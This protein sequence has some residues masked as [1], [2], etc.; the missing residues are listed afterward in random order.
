VHCIFTKQVWKLLI[1]YFTLPVAW[2]GPTFSACLTD[3]VT[4]KSA[5]PTLAVY[6]CWQVW[7]ER[8]NATFED[9]TPSI[10]A[11][12]HR[13]RASF[14]WQPSLIKAFTPKVCEISLSLGYTLVCFDGAVESTGLCCG[15]GG[16]FRTH[17]KRITKWF[18]NCG[19]GTN[20]K[21]ELL[22]LWT[23]LA[24]ASLWSI[25]HLQILGDS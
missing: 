10:L 18:I 25:D 12:F 3:W 20:T 13:V 17:S 21:E 15:A 23:S 11:V 24:L 16:F 22:G 2:K 14:Q 5:P 9:R 1:E 4:Q 19:E 6:M 8:N 7:T